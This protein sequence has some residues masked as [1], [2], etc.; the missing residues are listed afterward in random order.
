MPDTGG[1][2]PNLAEFRGQTLTLR[3]ADQQ[4]YS[5]IHFF[6]TT[7]DGSGGGNF[8][9]RFSDDTHADGQRRR[10]RLVRQP[11]RHGRPPRRD[12]PAEPALPHNAAATARSAASST[13]RPT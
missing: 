6:G 5:K 13:C 12:R 1:E 9:L 2:V 3:A 4:V 10:S 11:G 7:A 8:M